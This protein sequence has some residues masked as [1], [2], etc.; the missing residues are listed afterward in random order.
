MSQWRTVCSELRQ[1]R[2]EIHLP[3]FIKV[4]GLSVSDKARQGLRGGLEPRMEAKWP[5][6]RPR[7]KR[8]QPHGVL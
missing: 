1:K 5:V 3:L 4:H 8:E 7:S 6:C 2:K